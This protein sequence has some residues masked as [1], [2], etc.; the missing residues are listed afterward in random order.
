MPLVGCCGKVLN[1]TEASP[2]CCRCR[3]G[4]FPL[5][6]MWKIKHQVPTL[7]VCAFG[8]RFFATIFFS[9]IFA[10]YQVQISF[11]A[12]VYLSLN[13]LMIYNNSLAIQLN[14]TPSNLDFLKKSQTHDVWNGFEWN[15]ISL[16]FLR[17]VTGIRSWIC[18]DFKSLVFMNMWFHCLRIESSVIRSALTLQLHFILYDL[19]VLQ[20]L[21]F[22]LL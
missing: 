9:N 4:V 21:F 18:V 15:Y 7:G 5:S 12:K 19:N 3:R 16:L 20:N 8:E 22:C 14:V 6:R 13:D 2:G 10:F 17:I 11:H 1:V